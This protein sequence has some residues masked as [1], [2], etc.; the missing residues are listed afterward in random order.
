MPLIDRD[1]DPD[2]FEK[3]RGRLRDDLDEVCKKWWIG[4]EQACGALCKEGDRLG[5]LKDD[6]EKAIIACPGTPLGIA[7]KIELALYWLPADP[8]DDYLP[9]I[10]LAAK[11]DADRLAS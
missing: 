6:L 5:F 3:T 4:Y 10:L 11:A 2:W 8:Y 9:T 7:A 1:T